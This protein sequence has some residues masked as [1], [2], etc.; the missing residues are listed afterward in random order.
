M[1]K[2][3][4]AFKEYGLYLLFGIISLV[5]Y[6]AQDSKQ[7]ID[8]N[9]LDLYSKYDTQKDIK[10]VELEQQRDFYRDKY[11]NLLETL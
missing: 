9:I 10:I 8:N 7:K 5:A 4:A 3:N 1:D 6:F 11:F 2:A